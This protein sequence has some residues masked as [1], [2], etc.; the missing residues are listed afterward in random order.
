MGATNCN[1]SKNKYS[2]CQKYDLLC[3]ILSLLFCHQINPRLI[4]ILLLFVKDHPGCETF[5]ALSFAGVC[6]IVQALISIGGRKIQS[7]NKSNIF[8]CFHEYR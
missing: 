3:E 7:E 2:L 4:S 1:V 6:C 5:E 8:D